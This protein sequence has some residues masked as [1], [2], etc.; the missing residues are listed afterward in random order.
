MKRSISC[1]SLQISYSTGSNTLP[2]LVCDNDV[3][4][5][6]VVAYWCLRGER[7][8]AEHNL[9]GAKNCMYRNR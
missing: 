5:E 9:C 2:G 8:L 7:C 1:D 6:N 3:T 4:F